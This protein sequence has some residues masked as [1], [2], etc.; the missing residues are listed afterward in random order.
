MSELLVRVIVRMIVT[1]E[2]QNTRRKSGPPPPCL[3]QIPY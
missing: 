1:G 3:P 2:N